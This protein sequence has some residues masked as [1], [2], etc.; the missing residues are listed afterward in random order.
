[1]RKLITSLLLII[2]V[3]CNLVPL[4]ACSNQSQNPTSSATNINKETIEVIRLEITHFLWR[5]TI[6][7]SGKSNLR[8]ST[9]LESQLY[10]G[11]EPQNWWPTNLNIQVK[12]GGWGFTVELGRNGVPDKLTG[13]SYFFKIWKKDDPNIFATQFIDLVGPP[14]AKPPFK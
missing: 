14:P 5:N 6:D 4:S 10:I 11:Q 3:I 12:N 1:M 7:I 2:F 9:P 8:D 13:S